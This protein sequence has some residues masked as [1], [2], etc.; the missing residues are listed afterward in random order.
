MTSNVSNYSP[1][2]GDGYHWVHSDAEDLDTLHLLCDHWA[3]VNNI[4]SF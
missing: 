1:K 2:N 4:H 3:H